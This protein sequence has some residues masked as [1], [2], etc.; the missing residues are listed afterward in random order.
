MGTRP[1]TATIKRHDLISQ[2]QGGHGQSCQIDDPHVFMVVWLPKIAATSICGS[3]FQTNFTPW[4][5]HVLGPRSHILITK[6]LKGDKEC[7]CEI[8]ESTCNT[9]NSNSNPNQ[10]VA[11]KCSYIK[12]KYIWRL[13]QKNYIHILIYIYITTRYNEILAY[14][15]WLHYP[16]SS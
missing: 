3:R 5:M 8:S 11:P 16:S 10:G 4:H 13:E 15:V 7:S 9:A 14:L 1:P 6:L 2:Y 12:L